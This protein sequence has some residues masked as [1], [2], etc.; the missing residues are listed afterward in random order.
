[1]CEASEHKALAQY[2]QVQYPSLIFTSDSSG[3]RLSIGAAK[4]MLSLKSKHKIPDMIFLEPRGKFRGL[5]IEFK[6][7]GF[8]PYRQDGKMKAD[9][10]VQG[11]AKTLKMLNEKGYC[12]VFGLGF[13]NSQK[14]LDA[15]MK[16]RTFNYGVRDLVPVSIN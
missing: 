7:T 6:P 13:D 2:A 11:Q 14:I 12:A 3:V 8:N 1:M 10:R 16:G 15:Y 4:K 9:E 5:I